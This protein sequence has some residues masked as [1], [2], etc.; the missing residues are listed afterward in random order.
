MSNDENTTRTVRAPPAEHLSEVERP[1][2][3]GL[4][5]F[6]VEEPQDNTQEYD[7]DKVGFWLLAAQHFSSTW[8]DRSAEFA[9]PIYLIYIFV[10]TLLPAS[11]YGFVTTAVGILLSGTIGSQIDTRARLPAIRTCILSQKSF[12]SVCYA[13]FLI[14]FSRFTGMNSDTKRLMLGMITVSG[15]GLK[16]ATVGMN[17]CVERDWV[18]AIAAGS[19]RSN[20]QLPSTPSAIGQ[21]FA[22]TP[23]GEHTDRV[24]LR[25]NTTLRRIDLICKLVAPLFVSLLTS[26]VGYRL[27]AVI[28]LGMVIV[29]A[30]FETIFAGVVY[31]KF[32]VLALPRPT[33]EEQNTRGIHTSSRPA[34][35]V[36]GARE[37]A[38]RQI[39]SWNEFVRHPIF[40]SSVSISLLYFNVL[41]FNSPFISYL[42]S[43]TDF[44][45]PLIA[46]MR[47]LC[48]AT[49]LFGTFLMPWMENRIG[50]VRLIAVI[51]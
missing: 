49:G 24:L 50:Q 10:D 45:D 38:T 15:C 22:S 3:S 25:L 21:T 39:E 12:A 46:G 19:M 18:M 17:V 20:T 47:G 9:F 51:S 42:K 27:S 28:L 1:G 44:S 30:A 43:Q 14:L 4:L 2:T 26:T 32:P 8:G 33:P 6:R 11:I 41:S 37:W 36:Q 13:L 7:I 16:L 23:E 5:P 29:T 34:G 31:T 40:L 35:V 48:V